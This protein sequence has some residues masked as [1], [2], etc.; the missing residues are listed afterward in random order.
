MRESTVQVEFGESMEATGG[1]FWISAFYDF[2]SLCLVSV[3]VEVHLLTFFLL[4]MNIIRGSKIFYVITSDIICI[5][6]TLQT[7]AG[8]TFYRSFFLKYNRLQNSIC[9]FVMV[10]ETSYSCGY[11]ERGINSWNCNLAEVLLR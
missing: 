5:N 11:E 7:D 4:K 1:N 6:E 3:H 10:Y 2:F 8:V 9:E